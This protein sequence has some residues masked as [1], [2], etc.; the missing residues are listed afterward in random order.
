VGAVGAAGA[1]VLKQRQVAT[2]WFC[3]GKIGFAMSI[4][5]YL[6]LRKFLSRV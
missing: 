5:G 3:S 1:V 6:R 2:E 4:T